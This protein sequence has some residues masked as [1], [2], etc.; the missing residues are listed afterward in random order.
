MDCGFFP[1]VTPSRVGLNGVPSCYLNNADVYLVTRTYLTR[2]G[3]GYTPIAPCAFD[4]SRKR[5]TNIKNEFQGEFKIGALEVD[6][7]NMAFQRHCID[8][9]VA[10]KHIRLNLVFT[11]TDVVGDV[12]TFIANGEMHYMGRSDS[13]HNKFKYSCFEDIWMELKNYLCY[14]PDSVYINNSVES[15]LR[16]IK[17]VD[18]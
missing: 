11:H 16:K 12:F 3:N 17:N 18:K 4:L 6:T 5:E 2:H 14:T 9:V 8:N 7:L 15:N 13:E 10:K 1:H